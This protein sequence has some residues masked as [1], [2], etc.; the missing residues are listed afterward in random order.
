MV[1]LTEPRARLIRAKDC[2]RA[3]GSAPAQNPRIDAEGRSRCF[4]CGN[5]GHYARECTVVIAN[6]CILCRKQGH[7]ARDCRE[8]CWT[9]F[10]TQY[11]AHFRWIVRQDAPVGHLCTIRA[12][13]VVKVVEDMVDRLRREAIV[14][15][16]GEAVEEAMA[17][18]RS[19]A[20][21]AA[22]T[23]AREKNNRGGKP[24]GS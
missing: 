23:P 1:M 18:E 11:R 2:P 22:L 15:A 9:K 7:A 19:A 8:K 3:A 16:V 24:R 5:V 13:D 21:S 12:A 17:E 6:T 10:C 4:N 14:E 20:L